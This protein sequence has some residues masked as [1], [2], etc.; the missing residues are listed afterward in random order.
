MVTANNEATGVFLR[1]YHQARASRFMRWWMAELTDLVPNW[2]RPGQVSWDGLP[3]VSADA[4]DSLAKSGTTAQGDVVL[5]IPS[6][7]ALRRVVRLPLATEEN[8]RQVLEFQMEQYTPFAAA[9]VY[10]GHLVRTRDFEKGQLEVEFVAVP[11]GLL[12]KSLEKLRALGVNPLAAQVKNADGVPFPSNLLPAQTS[13]MVSTWRVG[14][15]PWLAVL[16]ALL[17]LA[18]LALPLIVQREAAIQLIPAVERAKKAAETVDALRRDIETQIVRHNYLLEKRMAMPTALQTL[19]ELTR[20]LPDDTWVQTF[21]WKGKEVLIQGETASSVKLIGLFEQSA[22]FKDASFRSP[23]T[24]GQVAG[25]EHFSLALQ[26]R[27]PWVGSQAPLPV[28]PAS[29][30]KTGGKS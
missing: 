28:P 12:D 21:D 22:M 25:V 19:E 14:L 7:M 4:I 30:A 27:M 8:L 29:A 24:K 9:Q 23:L 6:S 20:I 5:E 11:R 17:L 18:T 10:V 13:S 15:L 26:M 1:A 3:R 2:L 16:A